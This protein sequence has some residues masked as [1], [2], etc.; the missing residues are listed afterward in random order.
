MS[1]DGTNG[2]DE[3]YACGPTDDKI[4][5]LSEYEVTKYSKEAY[6]SS[7]AGNSRIRVTTDFAKA[8]NAYQYT[9][10]DG[11]GGYWW[12]RSPSYGRC[13]RA[14]DVC[15]DGDADGSGYVTSLDNGVVPA[16]SIK[17]Q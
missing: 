2:M 11:Y 15:Y 4:F 6:N 17:L 7:G 1:Y 5:L 9:T 3:K 16:L 14:R 12:L 10:D 13:N 8:N